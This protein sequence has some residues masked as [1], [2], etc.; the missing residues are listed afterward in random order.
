MSPKA[1]VPVYAGK[2]FDPSFWHHRDKDK[3]DPKDRYF[4][5]NGI[6]VCKEC[7]ERHGSGRAKREARKK[8]QPV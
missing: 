1:A 5:P 3:L 8:R 2:V 4:L 6:Q 7:T